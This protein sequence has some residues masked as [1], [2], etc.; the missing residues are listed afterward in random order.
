MGTPIRNR[1]RRGRPVMTELQVPS[2]GRSLRGGRISFPTASSCSAGNYEKR[3]LQLAA[4]FRAL[5]PRLFDPQQALSRLLPLSLAYGF[6][7]SAFSTHQISTQAFTKTASK[8]PIVLSLQTSQPS[9][10]RDFGALRNSH[11]C[12]RQFSGRPGVCRALDPHNCGPQSAWLAWIGLHQGHMRNRR[13]GLAT[14]GRV[15]G[16]RI[17]SPCYLDVGEDTSHSGLI[18]TSY[19]Q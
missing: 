15:G 17:M 3:H 5:H 14:L 1:E 16:W 12:I 11:L 2:S 10:Q 9:P 6:L 18:V 8:N 4:S 19:I 7:F 13:Y